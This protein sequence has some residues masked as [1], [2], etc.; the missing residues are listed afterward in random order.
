MPWV[1]RT[2]QVENLREEMSQLNLKFMKEQT[3]QNLLVQDGVA[4]YHHALFSAEESESLLAT[5]LSEI[6]WQEAEITMFGKRM[7][8]PRLQAW[9]G[10]KH[11]AYSGIQLTPLPWT[12]N[13]LKIKSRIEPLSGVEYNSVLLNLYRNGNDSMGWHSDDEPELG[14]NPTIGSVSFGEPRK[15][16]LRHKTEK[17]PTVKV[18]LASGSFLLMKDVIQS[19]WQHQI[20]KSKKPMQS[21]INLT[22]R[23]I[24]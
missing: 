13:L 15:F 9:Y 24:V 4:I 2:E 17:I 21:R 12:K 11:Y 10:D 20:P 3:P 5:L 7:K 1:W 14:E 16:H 23:A 19:H 18:E 8:I 6:D 22:F